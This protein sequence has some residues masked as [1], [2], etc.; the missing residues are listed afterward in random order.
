MEQESEAPAFVPRAFDDILR[1][2]GD[3]APQREPAGRPEPVAEAAAPVET[4]ETPAKTDD[5]PKADQP[6]DDAGRFA[7]KAA[8]ASQATGTP[9]AQQNAPPQSVPTSALLEERRKRQA[10]EQQLREMQ[11]RMAPPAPAMPQAPQQPEVPPEELIFQDPRRFVQTLQQQTEEALLATRLETSVAIARQNPDYA[12]AEA[13]LTAYAQSSPAAAQE[14]A[15][16]LRSHPAPALWAYQAGKQLLAQRPEAIE[17]RINA[18]VERRLA[19]RA[20]AQPAPSSA[21]PPPPA[22]LASARSAAPRRQWSGP[23]PSKAIFGAKRA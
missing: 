9:P 7:P 4:G 19:E 11:A 8:E 2:E 10:L 13:A 18:E 23:V 1:D 15:K 17:A 16:V 3:E 22:S 5:K 6:R 14:V 12:D 20:A 21:P